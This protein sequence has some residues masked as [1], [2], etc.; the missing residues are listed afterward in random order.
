MRFG[1]LIIGDELLRGKRQDRHFPKLVE[2][3]GAR[4]LH[5]SWAEYLGDNRAQLTAAFR[6]T[7][8][9]DD[10]VFCFGGI[11]STPDDQTR[12]SVAAALGVGLVLH[13]EAAA[14]I[15]AAIQRRYGREPSVQH[16]QMGEF[17]DG[18]EL[19]PNAYNGIPG[20]SLRGHHFMPGFPVMAHPMVEWLLDQRYAAFHHRQAEL[21]ASI[22][23]YGIPESAATPLMIDIET[24]FDRLKVFSLPHV[25][26]E[27]M[28]RH[29]E[30]GVRGDPTQV[31]AAIVD[32]REG[33]VALGATYDED[34]PARE[35]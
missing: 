22:F 30:L 4:G 10:A 5:L 29:I 7:F 1:A 23:V 9:T 6:R 35:E 14:L 17:P 31:K 2:L 28:R 32:L 19:I 16:L 12:Q 13:P 8:A 26:G 27:G 24:R 11:G 15:R 33:V 21:E 34:A 25:G 18:A 3:L 20:F